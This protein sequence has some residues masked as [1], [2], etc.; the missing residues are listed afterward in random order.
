M[1]VYP[2]LLADQGRKT[3]RQGRSTATEIV[4]PCELVSVTV[5]LAGEAW[6]PGGPPTILKLPTIVPL[7]VPPQP[8]KQ[9]AWAGTKTAKIEHPLLERD[10][11]I[12]TTR[13]RYC[14]GWLG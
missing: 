1:S 12:T 5:P 7:G 14:S 13:E 11:S 2:F 10:R 9:T 3:H 4:L 6:R 8:E